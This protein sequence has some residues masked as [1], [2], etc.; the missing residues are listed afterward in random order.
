M[1]THKH[2]LLLIAAL[3]GVGL[4]ALGSEPAPQKIEPFAA[5]AAV[6]SEMRGVAVV[7]DGGTI[8]LG[9]RRFRFRGIETPATGVTCGDTNVAR[10]SADALREITR[11]ELV[12]CRVSG[13]PD[14]NGAFPAQCST[15]ES[16]LN[17][18][19]VSQGWARDAP[20]ASGGAY[21]D[22]EAAAREA[23]RGVWALG[24]AAGPWR[25]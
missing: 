6:V 3:G 10:A 12:S 9:D 19:M 23:R 18:L 21:S 4:L 14:A 25:E 24:C 1:F 16:E 7:V 15:E 11:R 22:E 17:A 20:D 8:R 13:T 2:L 5:D